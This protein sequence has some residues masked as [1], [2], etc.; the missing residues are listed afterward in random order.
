MGIAPQCRK[1]L[2]WLAE[3]PVRMSKGIEADLGG[4]QSGIARPLVRRVPG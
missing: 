4:A 1:R 2:G 3:L